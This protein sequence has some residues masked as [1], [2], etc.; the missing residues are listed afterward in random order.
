LWILLSA[1]AGIVLLGLVLAIAILSPRR[2]ES[3]Q[4]ASGAGNAS[5]KTTVDPSLV[6]HWRLD[7]NTGTRASDAS[8][9]GNHGNL[10][11]GAVWTRGRSGNAVTLDG[12]GAFIDYGGSP[13]FNF[14]DK[15]AFTFAGWV[16]TRAGFGPIL[17][18]RSG[19]SGNP[20]IAITVGF[21]GG[22]TDPGHLMALV[23]DDAHAGDLARVTGGLVNDGQWHHFALVRAGNAISL[24]LDGALQGSSSNAGAGGPITTNLRALGTDR[25][26]AKENFAQPQQRFLQ[27]SLEDVRIYNRALSAPEIGALAK[28]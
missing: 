10:Q 12:R 22:G 26:W 17:T 18:Q 2:G 13:H 4:A 1:L 14:A 20:V 8:G 27:G 5:A 24:Y 11:A 21:D 28:S 23:R 7:E 15:A 25:V 3:P 19:T 6:G 9:R 16:N